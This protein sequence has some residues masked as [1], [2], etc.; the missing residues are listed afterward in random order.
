ML[1]IVPFHHNLYLY[2]AT[3]N[4]KS[5]VLY[6]LKKIEKASGMQQPSSKSKSFGLVL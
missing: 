5:M 2:F 1:A 6:K 3:V 4:N